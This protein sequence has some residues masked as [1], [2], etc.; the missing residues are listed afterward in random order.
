MVFLQFE[1]STTTSIRYKSPIWAAYSIQ[2]CRPVSVSLSGG[3]G[4]KQYKKATLDRARRRCWAPHQYFSGRVDTSKKK[5]KKRERQKKERGRKEKKRMPSDS[6]VIQYS[7]T[8]HRCHEYSYGDEYLS[9]TPMKKLGSSLHLSIICRPGESHRPLNKSCL[10]ARTQTFEGWEKE[11]KT[12]Q[13][14]MSAGS[15]QCLVGKK[16]KRC[17]QFDL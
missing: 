3:E 10:H 4:E 12:T 1:H 13:S 17:Q 8:H 11:W 2:A 14:Y 16:R 7:C 9:A 6:R 5:K 15:Q